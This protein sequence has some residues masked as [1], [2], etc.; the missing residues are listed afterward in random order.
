MGRIN[1]SARIRCRG[2]GEREGRGIGIGQGAMAWSMV[3]ARS[4]FIGKG[5]SI[6]S[7]RVS[8]CFFLKGDRFLPSIGGAK[9]GKGSF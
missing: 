8:K 2:A 6:R 3:M 7:L 4:S 9:G 1:R 5:S